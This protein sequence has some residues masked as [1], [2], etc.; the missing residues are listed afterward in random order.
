LNNNL[1]FILK[2]PPPLTGATYMNN[3]VYES[4]LL[5]NSF[6]ITKLGVSYSKSIN[7]LGK[8]DLRKPFIFLK[9]FIKTF[10]FCLNFKLSLVYFQP[11]ITGLTYIRDLFIIFICKLFRKKTILH[12]HGKGIKKIAENNKLFSYLYK[13][14][15]NNS[16]IIVLSESQKKDIDFTKP[17]KVFVLNNGI[18]ALNTNQTKFETS[19]IIKFLYLSNLLK[20]KGIVDLLDACKLLNDDNIDFR[21]DIVGSEG[22]ITSDQLNSI[23]E[24]YNLKSKIIY[25]GPKYN[26]DKIEYF[27]N[28]D[29][30]VF[31]TKNE[32]FGLVL[33]EAMQY[34]LP[35]IAS[36]EGAIPE[37]IEHNNSGLIFPSG[38]IIQLYKYMKY[39]IENKEKMKIMGKR[40]KVLFNEKF[41]FSEFE[42]ELQSIFNSVLQDKN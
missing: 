38:D 7:H 8:I 11:S 10:Y 22:D 37:I 33:L 28:C 15:L 9:L 24:S 1:L 30:F 4:K 36:D 26:N 18:P 40:G 32:A 2:T 31:P 35:I 13:L 3:L 19:H 20:S 16:Y 14:G 5:N 27:N 34:S 29:V 25:H 17:K 41:T 12:L 23:I 39:G 6:N 42:N 21:L